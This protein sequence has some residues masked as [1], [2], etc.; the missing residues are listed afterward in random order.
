MVTQAE[1]DDLVQDIEGA[2]WYDSKYNHH[3]GG[4][5]IVDLSAIAADVKAMVFRV[6]KEGIQEDE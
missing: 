3:F 1:I 4:A 5:D 2:H 6:G